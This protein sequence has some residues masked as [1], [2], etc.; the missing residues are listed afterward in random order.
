M[1]AGILR[2]TQ[3]KATAFKMGDQSFSDQSGHQFIRIMHPAASV[4]LNSAGNPGVQAGEES[5]SALY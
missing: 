2:T 5:V 1:A 3:D 4:I